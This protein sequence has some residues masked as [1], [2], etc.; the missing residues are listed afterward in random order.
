MINNNKPS[1]LIIDDSKANIIALSHILSDTYNLLA[2]KSG[3]AGLEVATSQH[4]DLI[5][6]DILMP[7]LDG[8][9]VLKILRENDSTKHIPVIF[10]SGLDSPEDE[11][12]GLT[13]GS[14]DYITKPFNSNIVKLRIAKQIKALSHLQ[15]IENASLT[16]ALTSL[17]NR[18]SINKFLKTTWDNALVASNNIGIIMIDIDNFK[19]INDTYG[20]L[21]GDNV[22]KHVAKRIRKALK[23]ET[24]FAGRFGGEEFIV[25]S[26]E[27]TNE[28]TLA[29]AEAIVDAIRQ[30]LQRSSDISFEH[31]LTVS[32]GVCAQLPTATTDISV[33]IENADKALYTAKRTGKDRAVLYKAE[34]YQA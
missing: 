20:H 22:L 18:A 16:D 11:E 1:I 23:R 19:S 13:L 32:A 3:Q 4:P 14:V 21:H 24:D 28:S 15:N 8:Y 9:D 25:V 33:F 10:I 2:A 31:P 27:A 26:P 29:L 7:G 5:L 30:P 34:N 17:P 6:L 12:K